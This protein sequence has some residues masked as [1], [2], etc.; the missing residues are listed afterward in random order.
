LAEQ[1]SPDTPLRRP[2][3]SSNAPTIDGSFATI[4]GCSTGLTMRRLRAAAHREA[5]LYDQSSAAAQERPADLAAGR[6]R[7]HRARRWPAPGPALSDSST[8]RESREV[9]LARRDVRRER[10]R[11][12]SPSGHG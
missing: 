11:V 4:S 6:L 8:S 12:T 7:L 2:A 1:A 3:R 5:G 10:D 9:A